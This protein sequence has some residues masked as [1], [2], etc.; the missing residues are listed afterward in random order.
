MFRRPLA[1]YAPL[2]LVIGLSAAVTGPGPAEA[3]DDGLLAPEQVRGVAVYVPF[4]VPITIDGKLGDWAAIPVQTVDYGPVVPKDRL[5]GGEFSFSVAADQTSFYITMRAVDKTIIAGKHGSEY[6]NEDSMEFYFNTSS[7]LD[8]NAYGEGVFQVN[9]NAADIGN[10]NPDGLTLTG[11]TNGIHVHGL[12]F[13]TS[14][15]WGFEASVPMADLGITPSHGLQIGFQAQ[16]NAASVQDRDVQLSWSIGDRSNTSYQDPSVFGT[17]IFFEVGQTAVPTPMRVPSTPSPRPTAPPPQ[18][19][20]NQVGYFAT[21]P[22]I[23]SF[24]TKHRTPDEWRLLDG[25]GNEVA[26][27]WTTVLGEDPASGGIVHQI[28]FSSYTTPGDGYVLWIYNTSSDPF[29]ISDDI[30]A[31]LKK[32]ALAYFYRNRSGIALLP[33][34]AGDDWA[35]AAGHLSDNHVT[36]YKGQDV[37]GRD[38]PGCDYYLDVAGGWYD[39]GDYGKYVVNGGISVWTLLDQYEHSPEA[40]G[41]GTL[42]IP[43]N[44]NGVPD[45]LDEARWELEFMLAM[46]VPDGYD[47]AGMVHHKMHDDQ[48]ATMPFLPPETATNRYLF[49]PSTAATL[50]VA[51]VGAQ[52]ARIWSDID[53]AFASRCLTVAEKAWTAANANPDMYA[54][55]FAAGGGD[56]GDTAVE[57]EFYWAA[58]ELYVT[59]GNDTYKDF[60]LD[61]PY[62]AV[63]SVPDWGHTAAL[64]TISLSLIPNDLPSENVQE[65]RDAIVASADERLEMAQSGYRVPLEE[66][67]WGSNSQALNAA[68]IMGLAYQYSGSQEYLDGVIL[69]MDYILGRNPLNTSY[70]TGYG[71]KSP[72]HPHHRFW[73]NQP[74]NGYPAPPPGVVVGG[75]NGSP[76]DPATEAAG[77]TGDPPAMSYVDNINSFTTNEVTINW[78]APLAW[79]ALF[80]DEAQNGGLV[81]PPAAAEEEGEGLPAWLLIVVPVALLAGGVTVVWIWRKG[82]LTRAR[83]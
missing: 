35:R 69:T 63:A 64:G 13:A 22:K 20:V 46:Q 37:T 53:E 68:L 1:I 36:C 21:G 31:A 33:E 50:N 77:L 19:S 56:Y 60:L 38:W 6:W 11:A 40:F 62:W 73:A 30:Y 7:N 83:S 67:V 55:S 16:L 58:A 78:N 12:V 71:T 17:A 28:D 29:K 8:R 43:E 49:P 5:E 15:G 82:L 42:D 27:G 61:S 39:A 65:C 76:G 10:K 57:D 80:V 25:S 79:V 3:A 14:D 41:D 52:C 44:A 26:N 66:Y 74:D 4:D 23:A 51:A 75:P 34:Y 24:A 72:A 47:L 81:A 48:W 45:I 32:D 18:V 9:V 54:V 70:V 2:L 59:T